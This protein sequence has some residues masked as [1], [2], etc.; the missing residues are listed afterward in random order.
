MDA[1]FASVEQRDNPDYRGK[2]VIVGAIPGKRGVVAAASY[3]AR[4]YGIHS[5]MPINQAYALCPQGIFVRPRMSVYSDV[6]H[7]IMII[8]KSFSP[9]IEQVSIDEAFVDITGTERLWGTPLETAHKIKDDVAAREQLTL[10]I[11]IAPNKFLAKIAS[12]MNKPNGITITPFQQQQIIEWLS[13]LSAG[14]L[15]GI[16]KKTYELLQKYNIKTVGDIQKMSASH[17]NSLLGKYGDYLYDISRGIDT[18]PVEEND[19]ILSISREHT[20]EQDTADRTLWKKALLTLSKSVARQ[21]RL[22]GLKGTV[23]TLTYRTADFKRHA[24]QKTLVKAVSTTKIIF[25]EACALL[26]S[27]SGTLT[28]LR[29]IGVGISGFTNELQTNL[30]PSNEQLQNLDAS[31][32]IVDRLVEK[33]GKHIISYGGEIIF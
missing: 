17:L 23:V 4:T 32:E 3:E 16:G 6:S 22:S 19:E 18:R 24:K 14:R 12:D 11:G 25:G 9:C 7:E 30:F 28:K 27:L 5:A 10:S 8:L 31:D 2:P 33:Y 1:F 26:E 29:L 21:A 20:F 15:P 13:P